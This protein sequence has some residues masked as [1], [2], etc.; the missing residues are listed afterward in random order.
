[1]KAKFSLLP[2]FLFAL[3]SCNNVWS[4][5]ENRFE[6]KSVLSKYCYSVGLGESVFVSIEDYLSKCTEEP[7][8]NELMETKTDLIEIKAFGFD[9][10]PF[11]ECSFNILSKFS[12]DTFKNSLKTVEIKCIKEFEQLNIK[13]LEFHFNEKIVTFDVDLSL[14]FD[15]EYLQM[16]NILDSYVIDSTNWYSGGDIDFTSKKFR[17]DKRNFISPIYSSFYVFDD[18]RYNRG[19]DSIVLNSIKFSDNLSCNVRNISYANFD[20]NSNPYVFDFY[21]LDWMDFKTSIDLN[22]CTRLDSEII[23]KFDVIIPENLCFLGGDIIYNVTINGI[24]Y[25]IKNM[26]VLLGDLL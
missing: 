1:M 4:D 14:A 15:D 2:T 24:N 10:Q 6:Y 19:E 21:S 5:S 3:T 12:N 20:I 11:S 8:I 25:E 13:S 7:F 23:F 16:P 17:V 9:L 22:T 26:Y 18:I